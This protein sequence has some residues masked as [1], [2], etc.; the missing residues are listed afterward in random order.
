[1]H[2]PVIS[3]AVPVPLYRVFDYSVPTELP[4][5]QVGSRVQVPFGRRTLIAIVVASEVTTELEQHKLRPITSVLDD[6]PILDSSLTMIVDWIARYYLSPIG[7]VYETV[8]PARLRRGLDNQPEF[9]S[10]WHITQSGQ[11][12]CVEQLSRAPLQSKLL[13]Q[14]KQ[15]PLNATAAKQFG[16]SW[17]TGLRGLIEKGWVSEHL[18]LDTTGFVDQTKVKDT[19]VCLNEQQQ[20]VVQGVSESTGFTV[21]LLHGVTGSGKTEVYL[22]LAEQ[23]IA[24]GQQV[25]LLVP[26]IGLTPQFV[27]RVRQRLAASVAVVHS[28]LTDN[29]R[30]QAWWS[31][32]QGHVDIVLG[33]RAAVFTPIK[34]LGLVA[35]DEEHDGS[36]K[37]QDGVRYHARDVAIV[38][39]KQQEIPIILGSATPS[40][41]SFANAQSERYQHWSITERATGS[42]LPDVHIID[43]RNERLVE[44]LS[45]ELKKQIEK[46]LADDQQVMLYINRRG[47]AA[48]LYCTECAW[49]AHCPRCDAHL[50]VH[51]SGMGGVRCH[52]CGFQAPTP[53]VCPSCSE[54]ALMPLGE[55]TQR[56]EQVLAEQFPQAR[57]LRMDKDSVSRKGELER[58]LTKIRDREVDIILG[59]QM[60]TKGHDFPAVTLV[61]VLNADQGL[62]AADFRGTEITFQQ[63]LQVAGRAGRHQQGAVYVQ[64][65][66]PDHPLFDRLIQQDFSAFADQVLQERK[67]LGYPPFA[68]FALLRAESVTTKKG[69]EFLRWCR[70]QINAS[71][72]IRVSD[73]VPAPMEKRAGRYRAQ[74][75]FKAQE[76]KPLHLALTRLLQQINGHKIQHSVRWSLDI[77]PQ[78]MY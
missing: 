49:I 20:T 30:Y 75:L 48:A 59:T 12:V 35:V 69:L 42:T 47:F 28:G 57:L 22:Q 77:D 40:M 46:C 51:Q 54:P 61:G 14:L 50:T 78:D 9:R 73:A 74:L 67:A 16:S 62:Y 1:M 37:Q 19:E 56:I 36:F 15:N 11:D 23:V 44:G 39:A 60:L 6:E 26:E 21:H 29:E 32:K 31:A 65:G 45:K 58:Q 8:L 25:L 53:T 63:L 41:E 27:D 10:V 33:T 64:T 66:F 43:T 24:N 34:N 18:E 55:G 52:H 68:H 5:P 13:N 2:L 72:E 70:G 17:R 7:L 76:R 3:V 4:I 71:D 38:R